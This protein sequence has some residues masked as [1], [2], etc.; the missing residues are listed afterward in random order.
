MKK[1]RVERLERPQPFQQRGKHHIRRIQQ[2]QN[3]EPIP[4]PRRG[5]AERQHKNG[6]SEGAAPVLSE[7]PRL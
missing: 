7:H 4:G 5:G 2:A 6:G 3:L 1:D